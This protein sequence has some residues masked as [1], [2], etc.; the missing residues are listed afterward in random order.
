MISVEWWYR[1]LAISSQTYDIDYG[2]IIGDNPPVL[3]SW[4]EGKIL[5]DLLHKIDFE[6]KK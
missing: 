1:Y 5:A 6:G 3:M 2:K 4:A